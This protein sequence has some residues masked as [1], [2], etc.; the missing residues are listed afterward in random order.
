MF[1]IITD[2]LT[3]FDRNTPCKFWASRPKFWENRMVSV[4]GRW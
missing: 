3:Q 4:S 1:L 2:A